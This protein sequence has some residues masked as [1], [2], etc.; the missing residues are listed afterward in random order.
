[1]MTLDILNRKAPYS[2]ALP[3]VNILYDI[4]A[5]NYIAIVGIAKLSVIVETDEPAMLGRRPLKQE[6]KNKLPR[7]LARCGY[8]NEVF[9]V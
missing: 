8:S 1:M 7:Y 6:I 5:V 2:H 4:R 3:V 9:F